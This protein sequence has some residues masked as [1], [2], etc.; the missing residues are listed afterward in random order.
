M[1]SRNQPWFPLKG[2][3]MPSIRIEMRKISR[4]VNHPWPLEK[5]LGEISSKWNRTLS[6]GEDSHRVGPGTRPR[7]YIQFRVRLRRSQAHG[8]Q[9][10]EGKEERISNSLKKHGLSPQN[11]YLVVREMKQLDEGLQTSLLGRGDPKCWRRSQNYVTHQG[12]HLQHRG[13]TTYKLRDRTSFNTYV[14][15]MITIITSQMRNN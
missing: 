9:L 1:T 7:V 4:A 10:R 12:H 8:V 11:V 6:T 2:A 13:C 15:L 3:M 5:S 14:M